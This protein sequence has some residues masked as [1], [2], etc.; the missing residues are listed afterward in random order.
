MTQQLWTENY[1]FN[2]SS[3]KDVVVHLLS[4]YVGML[5]NLD[6]LCWVVGMLL[7]DHMF[8]NLCCMLDKLCWYM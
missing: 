1:V 3:D 8:V 7:L 5:Q 2:K 4:C 6:K